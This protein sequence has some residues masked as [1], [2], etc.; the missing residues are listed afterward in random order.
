MSQACDTTIMPGR[1][2]AGGGAGMHER[3]HHGVVLA[4]C[5][6][7]LGL[8]FLLKPEAE[9]LSLFGCRWPWYCQLHETFGIRCA[10]CGLSRS[11]C[12]LARGDVVAA[13]GFHPLSPLVFVLCCLEVPYRIYALA[14][15]PGRT[16]M[17]LVKA[18]ALLVA[19]V[20][21]ALLVNWLLYLGEL[22][23]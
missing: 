13:L 5:A 9:G 1:P 7:V 20:A 2:A 15:G 22:L 17:G 16:G 11:F 18:H 8:A 21:A 19:L 4:V 14:I 3:A 23:V 12:C 6:T 10:L